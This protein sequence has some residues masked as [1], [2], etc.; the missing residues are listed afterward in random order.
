MLRRSAPRN[1]DGGRPLPT[2]RDIAGHYA[3]DGLLVAI[4][5]ALR[6]AG[7]DP[8]RLRPAE[9]GAV[10]EFRLGGPA[11]TGALATDLGFAPGM[12]MLDIGSELGGPHLLTDDGTA[13]RFA[14]LLRLV[15]D[16]VLA[17]VQIVARAA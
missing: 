3:R 8:E 16:S 15:A 7:L 17:P 10:D 4:L 14:G 13:K 9:P 6:A 1:D 11:A 12:R 5:D 2:E